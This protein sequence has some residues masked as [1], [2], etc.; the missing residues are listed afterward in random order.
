MNSENND[1]IRREDVQAALSGCDR[2]SEAP[3]VI[4]SLPAVTPR[5][6]P[7][8]WTQCHNKGGDMLDVW[9]TFCPLLDQ[10]FYAHGSDRI[11][12][13]VALIK[14]KRAERLLAALE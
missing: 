5:V 9:A 1:L 10:K 4:A 8:V 13:V 3:E 6:K 12:K 14:A 7:L 11:P 2:I